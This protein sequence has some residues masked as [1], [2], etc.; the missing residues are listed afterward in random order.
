MREQSG[1]TPK[2][3][4]YISHNPSDN[5]TLKIKSGGRVVQAKL[6][7]EVVYELV[8]RRALVDVVA[9]KP[10]PHRSVNWTKLFSWA[11]LGR[12]GKKL[13][14]PPQFVDLDQNPAYHNPYT[15]RR[16]RHVEPPDA[17]DWQRLK[18]E[19]PEATIRTV[20]RGRHRIR[21][22]YYDKKKGGMHS[23]YGLVSV[24]H[25]RG[26]RN[27]CGYDSIIALE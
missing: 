13:R 9:G 18:Q 20:V 17:V 6:P 25:P 7:A 23:R 21:I 16:Y 5:L 24:L 14:L 4:G 10:I 1:L 22:A 19:H 15:T 27:P 3:W 11:S 26:E 12:K 8:D 2:E